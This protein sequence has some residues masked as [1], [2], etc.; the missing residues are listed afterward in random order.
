M[1]RRYFSTEVTRVEL[2]L[3]KAFPITFSYAGDAALYAE[4]WSVLFSACRI[5]VRW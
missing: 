3:C 4:A 5:A 2:L 1:E